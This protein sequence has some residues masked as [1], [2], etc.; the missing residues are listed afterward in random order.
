[1]DE[2]VAKLEELG[3]N[4]VY[5]FPRIVYVSD[6]MAFIEYIEEHNVYLV[7]R[8]DDADIF[9]VDTPVEEMIDWMRQMDEFSMLVYA[10][11]E[12]TKF[13]PFRTKHDG[14][15][16]YCLPSC[17]LAKIKPDYGGK[18]IMW[19]CGLGNGRWVFFK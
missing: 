7:D 4:V 14:D 17:A 6:F 13:C 10:D 9:E 1:M 3:L 11:R 15:N 8:P 5:F 2:L 19:R 12:S 18:Q 16:I